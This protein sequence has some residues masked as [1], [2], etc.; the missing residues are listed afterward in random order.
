M[1]IL[2]LLLIFNISGFI[3]DNQN[4]TVIRNRSS[5]LS[6]RKRYIQWPKGSNFV[7]N[8]TCSKPLLRPQPLT[9]NIVYE[10]DVPFAVPPDTTIFFK[11][12]KRIKRHILERKSFLE[13][14]EDFMTIMGY[15]GQSCIK[16]LLCESKNFV[17]IEHKSLLKDLITVLFRSFIDH[18]EFKE[19]QDNC[20]EDN[21]KGCSVSL[22]DIFINSSFN[23]MGNLI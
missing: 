6:R 1:K 22:L 21:L 16:R 10:M 9:W 5:V 15:D 4:V 23:K 2:I 8:F 12:H 17:E 14:I 3:C 20:L 11:P 7:I 19:Y 18:K 13:K